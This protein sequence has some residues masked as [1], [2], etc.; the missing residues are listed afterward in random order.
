MASDSAGYSTFEDRHHLF[1]W[2]RIPGTQLLC[3]CFS[4]G[5]QFCENRSFTNSTC[6]TGCDL[7]ALHPVLVKF[8]R[9]EPTAARLGAQTSDKDEIKDGDC[10]HKK[11]RQRQVPTSETTRGKVN[12]KSTK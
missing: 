8:A 11:Y 7:R 5:V 6:Q 3:V 1:E 12:P 10:D 4:N 2:D 9:Q